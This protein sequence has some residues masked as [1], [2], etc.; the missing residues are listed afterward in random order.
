MSDIMYDNERR[1]VR[2]LRPPPLPRVPRP[3]TKTKPRMRWRCLSLILVG[4]ASTATATLLRPETGRRAQPNLSR[5]LDV[6]A[7]PQQATQSS[8]VRADKSRKR[9]VKRHKRRRLSGRPRGQLTM[10]NVVER[11]ERYKSQ[12]L[13][14]LERALDEGQTFPPAFTM[15]LDWLVLPG[16]GVK[17]AR[18]REPATMRQTELARCM[19]TSILGWRFPSSQNGMLVQ[20]F[21][22]GPVAISQR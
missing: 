9:E 18:L 11:I 10:E 7:V 3:S 6:P 17:W 8:P 5:R 14:C 16:G 20:G 21:P 1:P 19:R 4:I 13:R 22:L 12:T 15:T 2:A